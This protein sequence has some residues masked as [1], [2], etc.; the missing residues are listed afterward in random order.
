MV[1]SC[2]FRALLFALN[3]FLK[4][5]DDE[6]GSSVNIMVTALFGVGNFKLLY[7]FVVTSSRGPSLPL[8]SKYE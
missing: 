7:M 2:G 4:T 1:M 8:L 3:P 6:F 5:A